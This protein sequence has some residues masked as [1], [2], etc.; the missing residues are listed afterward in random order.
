MCCCYFYKEIKQEIYAYQVMSNKLPIDS[1]LF[2]R[3]SL[4]QK[5]DCTIK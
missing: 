1:D 3:P 4:S 2:S 5:S